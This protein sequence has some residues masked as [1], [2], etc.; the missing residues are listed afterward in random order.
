[1]SSFFEGWTAHDIIGTLNRREVIAALLEQEIPPSSFRSWDSI[2]QM[3]MSSS[4]DVKMILHES[5]IAKKDVEDQH[6]A[7]LLKCRRE[8]RAMVRN[9]QRHL[10]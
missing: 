3:I 1:M 9:V 2:G 6:Q 5:A 4:D 10:G 7:T 8:A